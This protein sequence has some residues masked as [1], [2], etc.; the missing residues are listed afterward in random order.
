[1]EEARAA[2]E[3]EH[4][5]AGTVE[6]VAVMGDKQQAAA[7][8]SEA[9]FEPADGVEVEV[10]G[11]LVEHEQVG[12]LQER[13]SKRYP[14]RLPTRQCGDLGVEQPIHAEVTEDRLGFPRLC[15]IDTRCHRFAHRAGGEHGLLIEHR[16]AH[17]AA[18]AD[19]TRLRLGQPGQDAQ[20]G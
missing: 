11:R 20:Q 4:L 10:V 9:L 19:N 1:M 2:I 6:H 3:L 7:P 12:F 8:A 15:G 14:L 5:R 13:S 17:A 16:N 18:T